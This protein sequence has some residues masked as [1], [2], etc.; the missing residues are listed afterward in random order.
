MGKQSC[1]L[2]KPATSLQEFICLNI[3]PFNWKSLHWLPI[4]ISIDSKVLFLTYKALN[5]HRPICVQDLLSLYVPCC[6]LR[7]QWAGYL[8][9]PKHKL[10]SL[11]AEAFRKYVP[12]LWNVVAISIC[13]S[14]SVSMQKRNRCVWLH[15]KMLKILF[16]AVIAPILEGTCV[17][18]MK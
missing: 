18:L 2:S 12:C 14:P 17:S 6:P 3:L 4:K 7:S 15:L 16:L 8:V 5:S 10:K 11:E 9:L 13:Y 1:A